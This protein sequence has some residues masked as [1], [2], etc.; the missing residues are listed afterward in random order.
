MRDARARVVPPAEQ[1]ATAAAEPKM[2][3]LAKESASVVGER[4]TVAKEMETLGEIPADRSLALGDRLDTEVGGEVFSLAGDG[5]TSRLR[6]GDQA[7]N[8]NSIDAILNNPSRVADPAN[9]DK[10]GKEESHARPPV[11]ADLNPSA[12]A[13][14]ALPPAS[15]GGALTTRGGTM[16][17]LARDG[18][19][20]EAA[21]SLE[22]VALKLSDV[23]DR[24]AKQDLG[25]L[26]AQHAQA[27]DQVRRNLYTAEGNY[28]LG[29]YD[30]AKRAYQD[31][32][33]VDP[34]NSAAR[35]G[36]EQVAAAKSDYYRAAYDNTRA[37]LLGRV[38][39]AWEL[40]VPTDGKLRER[41]RAMSLELSSAGSDRATWS[42]S[43]ETDLVT[44]F[45]EETKGQLGLSDDGKPSPEEGQHL[46]AGVE[47]SY[48]EPSEIFY[49]EA[50]LSFSRFAQ[51]E[52]KF[53]QIA[54]A[55]PAQQ[56]LV[57]LI[58][59]IPATENPY[60]TFSLNISDA[61][62]QLAKAALAKG[63]RPDPE[64]IKPEQFYNAVD[65]GDPAPSSNEPVAATIEQSAHP[66]IPG[67]NLVRV[68][69]RTGSAGRSAAQPLRLT[70]LVDQSGSMVREDRRASMEIHFPPGPLNEMGAADWC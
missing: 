46:V 15:A 11:L 12:S 6:S 7:I 8:R 5:V 53:R 40:S 30:D 69:L 27:V 37:E 29:K 38:D 49:K 42:E 33:K 32:L 19:K 59:E 18:K 51:R 55:E 41:E 4:S 50:D 1:T 9:R 48:A 16:P 68:A 54:P 10:G 2:K 31:A 64:S 39:A 3:L 61:S 56:K 26:P 13:E 67:R 17:G 14:R 57:D 36:L 70:L 44:K 23:G 52:Q 62:F 35:R 66:I 45:R 58:E 47:L 20:S 21:D 60:S 65:Y 34:H 25:E 22:D 24:S 43:K 63:E 28:N